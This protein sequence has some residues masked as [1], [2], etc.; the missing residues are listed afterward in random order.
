[1]LQ[2]REIIAAATV[3]DAHRQA[4]PYSMRPRAGMV[5]GERKNFAAGL[6]SPDAAVAGG[7]RPAGG[8]NHGGGGCGG[9][10]AK[11]LKKPPISPRPRPDRVGDSPGRKK[12][13][14]GG[15][16]CSTLPPRLTQF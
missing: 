8:E 4:N 10:G 14:G 15:V 16:P 3:D 9:W 7:M 5:L 2:R 11:M 1:M 6:P 12:K 13:G